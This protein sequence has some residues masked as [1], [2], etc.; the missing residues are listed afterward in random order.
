M[1]NEDNVF[2][3]FEMQVLNEVVRENDYEKIARKLDRSGKSIDNA[4]QR[5]KKKI[6][7]YL[8]G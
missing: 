2:S 8:W 7:R 6:I 1:H 5:I 3:D 4:M